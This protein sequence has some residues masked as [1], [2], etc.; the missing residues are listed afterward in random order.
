MLFHAYADIE[1]MPEWSPLLA[2]VVL[3]DRQ[4]LLSEWSLRVPRPLTRIVR[5]MGMSG[6]VRWRATHETEGKRLLRW[7]SISGVQNSGEATFEGLDGAASRT[8]I[9]LRMTYT[10]P[11]VAKPLVEAPLVQR[12]V[13][14]TLLSTM[15]RFKDTLEAEAVATGAVQQLA[16]TG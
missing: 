12:F 1:R 5:A 2:S 7:S 8:L 15:E 9:S 16:E 3:V 6:L 4:Q 14:R 11:D 10:L 13:H